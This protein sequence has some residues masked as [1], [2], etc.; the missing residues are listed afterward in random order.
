[1]LTVL[2]SGDVADR[3]GTVSSSL[4]IIHLW[5][6]IHYVWIHVKI[7][8]SRQ[9]RVFISEDRWRLWALYDVIN[10]VILFSS[11]IPYSR[12]PSSQLLVLLFFGLLQWYHAPTLK[13][14]LSLSHTHAHTH[15]HIYQITS[16]YPIDQVQ[17]VIFHSSSSSLSSGRIH[18]IVFYCWP[19]RTES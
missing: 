12:F 6:V 8:P 9:L 10:W 2:F 7:T 13:Y 11:R 16:T 18:I 5:K 19:R 15:I 14:S 17:W 1:M 4:I 3:F